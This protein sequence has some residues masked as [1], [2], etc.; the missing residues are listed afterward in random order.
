MSDNITT[1]RGKVKFHIRDIS[2]KDYEIDEMILQ[3]ITDIAN[4]TKLF[5][6]IIG[7]TIHEDKKI[8]DFRNLTRMNERVEIELEAVSI[9]AYTPEDIIEFIKAGAWSNPEIDKTVFVERDGQ[10]MFIDLLD[11]YDEFGHYIT[12]KFQYHGTA[13]Y[14][15]LDNQWRKDNEGVGKCFVASVIPQ[16][17]EILQEDIHEIMHTIIEGCKYYFNDTF[18]SGDDAQVANLY[19][20]RYWQSKQALINKHPTQIFAIGRSK[21]WL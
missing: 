7:F 20:Q 13:Q 2:F 14:Y 3:V 16:I 8:Y 17:D 12:D 9:Q 6:K 19:Y 5:K 18:G 10:S 4:E 1:I 21:A 15:C 11:V